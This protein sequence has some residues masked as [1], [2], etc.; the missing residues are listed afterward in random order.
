MRLFLD[1]GA[2]VAKHSS[3]DRNHANAEETFQRILDGSLPVTRMYTSDYVVAEAIT[4]ALARTRQHRCAVELGEAIMSSK[5]IEILKV[6]EAIF[7]EA[8]EIFKKH[9]DKYFSFVDCTS[10]ALMKKKGIRHAF[11]FDAHF[12]VAGFET[13]P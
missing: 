6:D 9:R 5:A 7:L 1:T 11:A 2:F 8:W 10:F 4:V 13:I 3:S 12:K